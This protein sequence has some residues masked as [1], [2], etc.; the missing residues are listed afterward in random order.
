M[1]NE[2]FQLTY[3]LTYVFQGHLF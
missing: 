1:A 2:A 3:Q